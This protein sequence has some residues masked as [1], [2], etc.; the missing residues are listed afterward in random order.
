MRP[1]RHA[2]RHTRA[3][4]TPRRRASEVSEISDCAGPRLI[5]RPRTLRETVALTRAASSWGADDA[6]RREWTIPPLS[7]ERPL[8][9]PLT[10]SLRNTRCLFAAVKPKGLLLTTLPRDILEHIVYQ[11]N[12]VADVARC[13]ET[14]RAFRDTCGFS[15]SVV[16]DALLLRAR[17]AGHTPGCDTCAADLLRAEGMRDLAALLRTEWQGMP[18]LLNVDTNTGYDCV[19]RRC[20]SGAFH[21]VP[22]G[23]PPGLRRTP[24]ASRAARPAHVHCT[25]WVYAG[26][27]RSP[28][29]T[30]PRSTAMQSGA[31][32]LLSQPHTPSRSIAT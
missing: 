21:S 10:R 23:H 14:C 19:I 27:G 11:L 25:H 8:Q 12:T 22:P 16:S 32:R 24:R 7:Y 28:M 17:D 31:F 13:E 29:L 4:H 6:S 30:R 26:N 2:R 5:M 9:P 1:Q 15:R 18:L 20:G 3:L